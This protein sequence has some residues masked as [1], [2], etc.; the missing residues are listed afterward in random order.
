MET[1]D[2]PVRYVKLPATK[3]GDFPAKE[4]RRLEAP[5]PHSRTLHSIFT[6][7]VTYIWYM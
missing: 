5:K 6:I 1:G 2:F 7:F 3:D 4:D